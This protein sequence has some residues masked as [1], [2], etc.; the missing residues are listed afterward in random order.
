MRYLALGEFYAIMANGDKLKQIVEDHWDKIKAAPGSSNNHQAW[1]GGYLDHV[2]ET[3]N[4]ARWLYQTCPRE[5]PFNL[6]AALEVMFL[7]DLE[8]PWKHAPRQE[9]QCTCGHSRERHWDEGCI[10]CGSEGK[11]KCSL[12]VEV[13]PRHARE[14]AFMDKKERRQFRTDL[15]QKFG[16][17]LTPEQNNALRYVE[18]V[19]DNEYTSDER[20]MNELAGFC[21]CCDIFSARV[22]HDQGRERGW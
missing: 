17:D 22:W 8:K 7:H 16:I 1:P 13:V 18:G 20:T 2:I 21:H 12:Y 15:I 10:M 3:L 9:P 11:K 14:F 6:S 5:F 4:I 19:P